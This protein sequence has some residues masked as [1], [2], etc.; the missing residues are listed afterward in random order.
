M[1]VFLCYSLCIRVCVLTKRRKIINKQTFQEALCCK[2][3]AP[4]FSTF[5]DEQLPEVKG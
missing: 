2:L 1:H 4:N 5:N 3:L